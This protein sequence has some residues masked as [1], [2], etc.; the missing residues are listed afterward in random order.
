[1]ID[2]ALEWEKITTKEFLD[3]CRNFTALALQRDSQKMLLSKESQQ[4]HKDRCLHLIFCV[5]M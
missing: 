4:R 1:M 3:L 5:Y 2:S